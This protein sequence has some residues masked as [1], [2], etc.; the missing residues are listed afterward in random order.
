MYIQIYFK[1]N[2][3]K[4]PDSSSHITS[5][6]L[7]V[8]PLQQPLRFYGATNSERSDM[9]HKWT[10]LRLI[11]LIFSISWTLTTDH[12]LKVNLKT[13]LNYQ[14]NPFMY[15]VFPI[16]AINSV[17]SLKIIIIFPFSTLFAVNQP[18]RNWDPSIIS[19]L[20]SLSNFP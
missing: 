16:Q 1:Y 18:P 14:E 15:F 12:F 8:A 4:S 5:L 11:I 19:L 10:F 13:F 6:P 9:I 3:Y 2:S 17:V 20:L 7:F